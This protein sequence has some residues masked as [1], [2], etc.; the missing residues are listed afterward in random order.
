VPLVLLALVAA[1]IAWFTLGRRGTTNDGMMASGT[2]EATEASLG[3]QVSGRIRT[4]VPREG[5]QVHSGAEL[6]QLDRT[7]L[8]ARR[9]Q[10]LA[11][12]DAARALL[13]DLAR[14]AR[15]EEVAQ[16]RSAVSA[17]DERAADARRDLER[18]ERLFQGGAVS[19]EAFEKARLAQSVAE[20]QRDQAREQLKLLERGATQER[21]SAQ[22]AAVAQADAAIQQVDALLTGAVITAPF[23]GTVTVRDREPGE[24]VAAGAPVLTVVNL[25]DR[26]IRIYVREDRL[27]RLRLGAPVSIRSDTYP[28]KR[29]AGTISYISSAAEFT[30]RNVQTT[31]ERV[32]LVY[33]VKVRITGDDGQELK[34]GMPADVILSP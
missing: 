22:R 7:E 30:P 6:A 1:A 25:S 20:S 16:L 5:D 13:A 33:A 3:F 9:A 23:D 31:E 2:V 12:R 28:E 21:L 18:V 29:Y 32:K 11:Q 15:T 17:A 27:G 24:T 34:P 8:E 10:A 14:G 19:R 4:I 26:W